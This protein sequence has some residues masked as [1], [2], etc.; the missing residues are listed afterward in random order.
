LTTET[1]FLDRIRQHTW[2]HTI[3]I[4][5]GIVTPGFYDDRSNADRIPWPGTL[6][7]LR[8]LD[9]GTMDGFWA[10]EM[11][12]RGAAEIVAADLVDTSKQDWPFDLRAEGRRPAYDQGARRG[13]TFATASELLG[14][15]V[16]YRDTNIYDLSPRKLG[17]FDLVFF[18]RIIEHL[19]NP[20][21]AL[22]AIRSVCRGWVIWMDPYR[23]VLS[24]F[25]QPLA[26]LGNP[27][28][29]STYINWFSFNE[30][31]MRRALHVAGFKVEAVTRIRDR[32]GPGG[33]AARE[34]KLA[35]R[36][37]NRLGLIGGNLAIRARIRP[38]PE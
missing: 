32:S 30:A 7:G 16:Q 4:R 37:R 14:F 12:R 24:R 35:R 25:N 1:D 34:A 9:V 20:M 29:L 21:G 27:G 3:E 18:G 8:C 23:V 6:E 22:E 13:A 2:Y 28:S 19:R 11:E 15:R 17:E 36:L 26:R 33:P 31:G 38:Q 10:F 5:P